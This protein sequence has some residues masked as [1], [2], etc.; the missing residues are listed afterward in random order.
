MDA[1]TDE[2]QIPRQSVRA[3]DGRMLMLLA[4]GMASLVFSPAGAGQPSANQG[5]P[6]AA[7]AQGQGST[8]GATSVNP[9]SVPELNQSE[10]SGLKPPPRPRGGVSEE[11]YNARKAAAANG[12]GAAP[13]APPAPAPSSEPPPQK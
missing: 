13:S 1:K 7:A 2:R 6:N 11:E 3:I 12:G 9:S 8:P 10:A 4:F 5:G